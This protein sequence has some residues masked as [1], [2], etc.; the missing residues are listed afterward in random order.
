MSRNMI[1]GVEETILN[2][3]EEFSHKHSWYAETSSNIHYYNGW[4]TNKAWKINKK[5]IIPLSAYSWVTDRLDY[6]YKF[7]DKLKDIQRV[8]DYLDGG[9]TEDIDLKQILTE[10]ENEYQTK[11]IETKYFRVSVYKKGTTHLVFTN[12]ELLKKFN[13]F[14]CQRKGFLPP[15]YGKTKYNDM[16]NEEQEVINEFEG[17]KSYNE[18]VK[19]TEYYLYNPSKVLMLSS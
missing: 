17:E 10:A 5:V 16:T 4:K 8:F 2:L 7:F 1:K 11:N 13:I 18:T 15:S 12:E 19:N 14:G 3:F 6:K 9:K